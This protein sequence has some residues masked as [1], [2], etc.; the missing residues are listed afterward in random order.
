MESNFH[1]DA[2]NPND[3]QDAGTTILPQP[4]EYAVRATSIGRR[5]DSQTGQVMEKDGYQTLVLNRI[6]IVDPQEESG[7]FAVFQDVR[8]K[9]FERKAS[10]GR[11]VKVSQALDLIRS[12]DVDMSSEVT[13]FAE[14]IDVAEQALNNGA[15]FHAKLG[16]KA[17]DSENAKEQLQGVP[18]DDYETRRKVWGENTYYTKAFRR[19]DGSYNTAIT[20]KD[21][22]TLQGKLVIDTFVPSTGRGAV[23][24]FKR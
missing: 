19:P 24:P 3:Y 12:I 7:T 23:G 9:P 20:T 15:V 4:G 21:G 1:D 22:K 13:G 8:T 18:S 6:E 2:F 16:L 5:K 17:V 14:A 11:K 10:G